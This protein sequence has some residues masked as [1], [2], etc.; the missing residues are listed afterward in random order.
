MILTVKRL[1]DAFR[2]YPDE[3]RVCR[4]GKIDILYSD[5]FCMEVFA[6]NNAD[7]EVEDFMIG[8]ED[9]ILILEITLGDAWLSEFGDILTGRQYKPRCR[10]EIE[11]IKMEETE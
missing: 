8:F 1:F 11:Q 6:Y 9:G 4:E 10:S 3:L 7:R 2:E 5:H